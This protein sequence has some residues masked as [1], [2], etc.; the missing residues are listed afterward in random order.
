MSAKLT[1]PVIKVVR[2]NLPRAWERAVLEVWRQGVEIPTQYDRPNDPP[3][4]DAIGIVVVRHP[5]SEPRIH[6]AMPGGLN[7][8][9][10]YEEEVVNG[11]HDDWINPNEGKWSYTYH[12]RL[13]TYCLPGVPEPIDQMESLIQELVKAPFTRRAQAI[14]WQPWEDAGT[15]HPPCLQRLWFRVFGDELV[16]D[17][18]IRSN[19]AYKA[20]FMN[21]FAFTAVQKAV[22]GRLSQALGRTITAGQYTHMADSFHIYGSY[23]D[24]FEGFLNTLKA[25]SFSQRTFRTDEPKARSWIEQAKADVA[26]KLAAEQKAPD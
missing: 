23:F 15:E 19:D 6:R 26:A 24:E 2:D 21:M 5:F 13:F 22:A 17:V 25:R 20:G 18:H 14:T 1:L 3:S 7:D 4:R 12:Q 8:L 16:M 9:F 10:M 11:V